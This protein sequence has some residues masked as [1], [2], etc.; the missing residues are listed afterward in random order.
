LEGASLKEGPLRVNPGRIGTIKASGEQFLG[1]RFREKKNERTI[2]TTTTEGGESGQTVK[3]V[4][5]EGLQDEN[6]EG[7]T[8]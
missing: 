7:V 3:K 5:N 8:R 6:D 4:N 1:I 2:L